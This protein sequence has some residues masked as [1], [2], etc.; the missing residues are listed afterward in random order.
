ML[1]GETLSGSYCCDL[2][3]YLSF[4][5]LY[6]KDIQLFC[7]VFLERILFVTL[8]ECP[9]FNPKTVFFILKK[10]ALCFCSSLGGTTAD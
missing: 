6:K 3:M 10:S 8:Q 9:S 2:L 5:D 1:D 4:L 7:F